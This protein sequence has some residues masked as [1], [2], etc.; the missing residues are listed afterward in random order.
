MRQILMLLNFYL[1]Y[2][3][4]II[5]TQNLLPRIVLLAHIL[6]YLNF[7]K[8]LRLVKEKAAHL[9]LNNQ[10]HHQIV[11]LLQNQKACILYVH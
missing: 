10:G 11:L 1:N 8:I 7:L 9:G 3:H 5:Q 4:I 2:T 6:V